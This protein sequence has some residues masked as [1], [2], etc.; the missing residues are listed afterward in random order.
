MICITWKP[1][2]IPPAKPLGF[3]A[4]KRTK[5]VPTQW[6][7][8]P[9]R[10]IWFTVQMFYRAFCIMQIRR[11]ISSENRTTLES[12]VWLHLPICQRRFI[13]FA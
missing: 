3:S 12:N 4:E 1:Q 5:Q 8:S 11:I 6:L 10:T 9:G 7:H 2:P 13:G